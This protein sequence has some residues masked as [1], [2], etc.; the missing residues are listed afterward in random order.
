MFFLVILAELQMHNAHCN[1]LNP[2]AT[3]KGLHI[4]YCNKTQ[5][6]SSF[7]ELALLLVCLDQREIYAEKPHWIVCYCQSIQQLAHLIHR[8]PE[9]Q[10]CNIHDYH[11]V[12]PHQNDLCHWYWYLPVELFST[13]RWLLSWHLP[14]LVMA[15]VV[16]QCELY[17][18][19]QT[20][21]QYCSFLLYSLH[22]WHLIWMEC[23]LYL[24]RLSILLLKLSCRSHDLFH[25]G[26][27]WMYW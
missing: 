2:W 24:D 22:P 21:E 13:W 6:A 19:S 27:P 3:N 15:L 10:V 26:Y 18:K 17:M 25:S 11:W 16:P 9:W 5:N 1:W 4:N 12:E 14:W 8:I 23:L 20:C 7:V